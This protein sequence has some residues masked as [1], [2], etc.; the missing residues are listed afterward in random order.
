MNLPSRNRRWRWQSPGG[1]ECFA[2]GGGNAAS[3]FTRNAEWRASSALACMC[4]SGRQTAGEV[5]GVT[6]RV[7][8]QNF[9]R[10]KP[11]PC[12]QIAPEKRN[13]GAQVPEIKSCF[14]FEHSTCR[15][16]WSR[17]RASQPKRNRPHYANLRTM[18]AE[19]PDLISRIAF[20]HVQLLC[21]FPLCIRVH[22]IPGVVCDGAH[23]A[24]LTSFRWRRT[25]RFTA[26]ARPAGRIASLG[27]Y[28]PPD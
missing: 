2:G 5:T 23:A 10:A 6:L 26:Y 4:V 19:E 22:R 25:Q 11:S 18:T 7:G 28:S 9:C 12:V 16:L 15:A 13:I 20:T 3:C 1:P 24:V 14:T 27:A 17:L 8:S 21:N